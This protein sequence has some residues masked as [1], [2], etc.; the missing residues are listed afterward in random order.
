MCMALQYG[1]HEATDLP[2]VDDSHVL[3]RMADAEVLY[4]SEAEDRHH[5][6]QTQRRRQE[7]GCRQTDD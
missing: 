3:K 4:D 5:R 7:E 2:G 6:R 1:C